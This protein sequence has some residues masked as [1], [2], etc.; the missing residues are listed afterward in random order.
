MFYYE[1]I[2]T[3]LKNSVKNVKDSKNAYVFGYYVNEPQRYGVCEFDKKGN[4]L[5]IEETR[6]SEI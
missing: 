2:T 5:S 4:V 1:G 3:L 6:R